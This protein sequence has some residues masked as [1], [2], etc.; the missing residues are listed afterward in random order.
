MLCWYI[1]WFPFKMSMINV[2][3]QRLI[4]FALLSV[5]RNVKG[6][7]QHHG[8]ESMNRISIRHKNCS[9]YYTDMGVMASQISDNSTVCSTGFMLPANK[10]SKFRIK[11]TLW[12]YLLVTGDFPHNWSVM[13]KTFLCHDVMQRPVFLLYNNPKQPTVEL[14]HGII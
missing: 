7:G 13:R 10:T 3:C 9:I 12:R 2:G 11:F 14:Y 4:E 8:S 6:F 5:L 1:S